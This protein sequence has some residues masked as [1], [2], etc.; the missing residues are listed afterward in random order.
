[1]SINK[2][3]A[4]A[5]VLVGSSTAALAQPYYGSYSNYTNRNSGAVVRDHRIDVD[6]QWM[7]NHRSRRVVVRPQVNWYAS[8][9]YNYQPSY[10]SWEPSY[11]SYQPAT[12]PAYEQPSLVSIQPPTAL[13]GGQLKLGVAGRMAGTQKLQIK[14]AGPGGTY[15]DE[16]QLLY[17]NHQSQ[18][19]AVNRMV[20]A[21]NP[22]IDIP[23]GDGSGVSL[24]VVNGTYEG[25]AISVDAL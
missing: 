16:V 24:V 5:A 23:L 17:L 19:I 6:W 7:R 14:A 12:E 4:T 25:G 9:S 1:M 20:D 13:V 22:C 21:N 15:I 2:L 11:P 8:S 18:R 10:Q 3:I